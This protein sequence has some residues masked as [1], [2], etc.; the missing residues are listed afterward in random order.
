MLIAE[1]IFMD[2]LTPL[3]RNVVNLVHSLCCAD[4][5]ISGKPK[6]AEVYLV[7]IPRTELDR[8]DFDSEEEYLEEALVLAPD[9]Q[10]ALERDVPL[11]VETKAILLDQWP[12]KQFCHPEK[13]PGECSW[14]LN[15]CQLLGAGSDLDEMLAELLERLELLFDGWHLEMDAVCEKR[16]SMKS[17]RA[18]WKEEVEEQECLGELAAEKEGWDE[19]SMDRRN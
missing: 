15:Y 2:A 14:E 9:Y 18:V 12:E 13:H 4:V 7:R 8:K 6:D 16:Y 1:K 5:V 3:Q 19:D 10:L 17:Y 11:K